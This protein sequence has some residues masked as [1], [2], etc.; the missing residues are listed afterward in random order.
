MKSYRLIGRT[1]AAAGVLGLVAIASAELQVVSTSPPRL[2]MAPGNTNISITFDRPVLRSSF[3]PQRFYAFGRSTGLRTGGFAFSNGDQTVTLLNDRPFAAGETVLVTLARTLQ[4]ADTTT[5]RAAGYHFA[6]LIRTKPAA[7]NFAQIASLSNRDDP[8]SPTR[9]YGAAAADFNGDRWTDL[10]TVNEISGDLRMFLNRADGSGLFD[11][12][13]LPYAPIGD[14]ASPNDTADFNFD[15]DIDLVVANSADHNL[16][17]V[18]GNGDGTFQPEI[19]IPVSRTPH[20]VIAGDLDGDGDMDIAVAS[21][22]LGGF[23]TVIKNNG[24]GT[25]AAPIAYDM[26]GSEYGLALGDMDND[27]IM[28]LVVGENGT[29]SVSIHLG[30]GNA[31]YVA[32]GIVNCGGRVW[33]VQLGDLNGDGY[34]D[35]STANSVEGTGGI[36][37]G[38]GAGGWSGPAAVYDVF[39]QAPSTDL[40]DLDGDGDLDWV[41]SSFGSSIWRLYANDGLGNF[42]FV[43]DFTAD[44]NPSCAV[45]TDIDN[46]R[47][48]DVVLT[49]EIADVMKILQNSGATP[50][51]DVNC[52]GSVDFFDIDPFLLA[53]FDAPGY[54]LQ[55][56][57]CDIGQADVNLDGSVD[58]FD[59]DAFL[60][61]L[62]G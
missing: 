59:I 21:S 2:T 43:Q 26:G 61:A 23:V 49:D 19:S 8:E 5:L 40:G 60:A 52:D 25:F 58:F 20:G 33:V 27:G 55:Y 28:D 22:S 10:C 34:C 14:E 51:G 37:L 6:F 9:I 29:E 54:E 48:L 15:G 42:T 31:T 1:V 45:L 62:F 50:I 11:G 44:N 47:D 7:M 16:S 57:S 56:P 36:M 4:A 12:P 39:S 24:N 3:T 30:V 46:D 53:L 38:D 32:S 17:V 41:L 13:I 18:M 35:A